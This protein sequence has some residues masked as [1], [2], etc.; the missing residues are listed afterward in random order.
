MPRPSKSGKNRNKNKENLAKETTRVYSL[1][2]NYG[3]QT[4]WSH[5]HD[6]LGLQQQAYPIIE[7]WFQGGTLKMNIVRAVLAFV[8]QLPDSERWLM[9]QE[10]RIIETQ[11]KIVGD[12]VLD[13]LRLNYRPQALMPVHLHAPEPED[14]YEDTFLKK[15]LRYEND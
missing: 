8:D 14:D 2:I 7:A 15:R 5:I 10:E 13:Y 12:R 6:P 1:A 9:S 11:A 4:D 3:D